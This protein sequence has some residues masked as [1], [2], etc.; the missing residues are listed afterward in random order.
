[1]IKSKYRLS[2][3]DWTNLVLK[4]NG[5]C[6][7][8]IEQFKSGRDCCTDHNHKTGKVRGLLCLTCNLKLGIVEKGLDPINFFEVSLKYLESN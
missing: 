2:P 3:K 1:M 4:S 5:R 7:M 8:C 6:E